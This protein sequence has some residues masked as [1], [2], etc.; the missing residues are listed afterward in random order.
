MIR[1]RLLVPDRIRRPPQEGF[2]WIDRRF[3]REH[4][5]RLGRDAILLYF[6]FCAV[7]DKDGLSYWSDVAISA[8]LRLDEAA[9]D[10]AR[11]ELVRCDLVAY[12]AP[13]LQILA[14]PEKRKSGGGSA[15][16]SDL[17]RDLGRGKA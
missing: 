14:L 10:R 5:A 15:L 17:L 8:R 16:L 12:E 4:A 3:V 11:D 13:L 1:K 2:S 6:F 9:L 7:S